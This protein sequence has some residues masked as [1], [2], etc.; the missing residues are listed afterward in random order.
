ML[1]CPTCGS[2]R[3]A[4]VEPLM[5]KTLRGEDFIANRWMCEECGHTDRS[6]AFHGTG[7][8]FSINSYR[9]PS[10]RRRRRS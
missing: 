2:K 6:I 4:R 8:R 7:E 10:M 9:P 5:R 3:L 1:S